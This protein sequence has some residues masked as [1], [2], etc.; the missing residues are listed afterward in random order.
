[1][2]VSFGSWKSIAARSPNAVMAGFG[3]ALGVILAVIAWFSGWQ[4]NNTGTIYDLSSAFG[5]MLDEIIKHG[6]FVCCECIAHLTSCQYTARMPAVPA[7]HTLLYLVVGDGLFLHLLIK[8][9]LIFSLFAWSVERLLKDAGVAQIHRVVAVL[10]VCASPIALR[11]YARLGSE[12]GYYPL[13]MLVAL[14][15]LWARTKPSRLDVHALGLSLA[16]LVLTKSSL[17]FF[18]LAAPFIAL[19]RWYPAPRAF[20]PLAYVV[21]TLTGWSL[22]SHETSGHWTGALNISSYDGLNFFKANNAYVG[23]LYPYVHLDVLDIT[24]VT[25]ALPED[26]RHNEWAAADYYKTQ[27]LDWLLASPLRTAKFLLF[28]AYILLLD[29]VWPGKI[30]V[31]NATTIDE[32]LKIPETFSWNPKTLAQSAVL[33]AYKLMFLYSLV[34]AI[35]RI[36]LPARRFYAWSYLVLTGAFA[37]PF[38][39]GF[40]YVYHLAALYGMSLLYLAFEAACA[41]LP[42]YRS[43]TRLIRRSA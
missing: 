2:P 21:I 40:A 7:F 1:M 34:L 41:G 23:R 10:I 18:S 29:P 6:R 42:T 35:S 39:V 8:N 30:Y 28:K 13:I 17:A 4:D 24:G 20:V 11:T 36:R 15:L 19:V 38:V 9:I 26:A 3:A 43:W 31:E 22:W 33:I 14:L 37:L 27:G 32:A 12:E 16:F 5:P 25:G